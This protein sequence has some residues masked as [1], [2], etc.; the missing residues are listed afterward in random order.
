[1]PCHYG[2]DA[3]YIMEILDFNRLQT[4]VLLILSRRPVASKSKKQQQT[5]AFYNI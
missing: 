4:L 1:M 2:A 3:R 5:A